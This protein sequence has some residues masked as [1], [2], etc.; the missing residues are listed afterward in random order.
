MKNLVQFLLSVM[1]LLGFSG[2]VFCETIVG[3]VEKN[4]KI[5]QNKVIDANTQNPI[6]FATVKIPSKNYETKTDKDGFFKLNADINGKTIM[7]IEKSGYKP[8]SITI[9]KDDFSKPLIIGIEKN[10]LSNLSLEASVIHLGDDRFSQHSAN[11]GEFKLRSVGPF[12][13]KKFKISSIGGDENAYFIIGSVIGVD[14]LLS[15]QM[16]QSRVSTAYASPA[17][18]YFNG[19]KIGEIKF[20]SDGQQILLPRGL[21][22]QNA[23]NE[24][25]ITAGK[26][27]FQKNYIDY[28]DIELANLHVEFKP[29]IA[30]E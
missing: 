30:N 16:G 19:Q 22:K 12:F 6:S 11:S 18:I 7:S 5:K 27:L 25:S 20:N 24:I 13:S 15:R 8:F 1:V 17:Q 10:G 29:V 23:E 14:T 3:N 26:N 4:E 9:D 2:Q 28:D 21:V